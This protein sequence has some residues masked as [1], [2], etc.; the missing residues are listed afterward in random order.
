M[1]H[2][3]AR[4]PASAVALVAHFAVPGVR[5]MFL[6]EPQPCPAFPGL[7]FDGLAVAPDGRRHYLMVTIRPPA[8][9]AVRAHLGPDPDTVAQHGLILVA[10]L[11]SHRALPSDPGRD[12]ALLS[13][14]ATCWLETA[15]ELDDV[16]ET[17]DEHSEAVVAPLPAS[18]ASRP[19]VAGAM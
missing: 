10:A 8:K 16:T 7:T 15:A 14:L 11:R 18:A 19:I 12:V 5:E 4:T 6:D 17:S 9:P 2:S 1:N 3:L 13:W